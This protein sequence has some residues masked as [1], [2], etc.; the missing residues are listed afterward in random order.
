MSEKDQLGATL[1]RERRE[2]GVTM[3]AIASALGLSVGYLSSLETG[4]GRARWTGNLVAA[5]RLAVS[6]SVVALATPI[7]I[8]KVSGCS[9]LSVSLRMCGK[10]Y[11]RWKRH[12]DPSIALRFTTLTHGHAPRK[13]FSPE[14]RTWAGMLSR[15]NNSNTKDY[16][17]YG[18]RGIAVCERWQRFENFLAD[19]GEKPSPEHTI[20]RKNNNGNYEPGNCKWATRLEQ[21]RNQRPRTR[22][23]RASRAAPGLESR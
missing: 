15:C 7:P 23:D 19:M 4:Y 22:R 18:G 9:A 16:P 12:G 20:E 8:C 13:G 17:Y 1:R 14:Y 2:R 3:T 10:H 21:A 6:Q 11:Q 5:Y